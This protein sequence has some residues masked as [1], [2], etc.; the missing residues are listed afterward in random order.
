[1]ESQ[2][3]SGGGLLIDLLA[4]ILWSVGTTACWHASPWLGACAA[5]VLIVIW[6][7]RRL[8]P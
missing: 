2:T 3:V 8:S 5:A 1:M 7:S 6:T 4:L